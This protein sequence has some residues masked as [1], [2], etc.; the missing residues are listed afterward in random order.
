[1]TITGASKPEMKDS[2]LSLDLNLV[3]NTE[4]MRSGHEAC[5]SC[6]SVADLVALSEKSAICLFPR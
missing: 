1:M 3:Y 5:R 6:C 4:M 2:G